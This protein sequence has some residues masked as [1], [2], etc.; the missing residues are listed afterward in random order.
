ME[1]SP[2]ESA[3]AETL[4]SGLVVAALLVALVLLVA[5][6]IFVAVLA[7]LFDVGSSVRRICRAL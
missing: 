6:W 4:P 1:A 5:A 2:D 7:L 3:A